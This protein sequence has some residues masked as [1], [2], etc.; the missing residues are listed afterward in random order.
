MNIRQI[1][2]SYSRFF[3]ANSTPASPRESLNPTDLHIKYFILIYFQR[4]FSFSERENKNYTNFY[5]TKREKNEQGKAIC[6][7]QNVEEKNARVLI[8][9][10]RK[11]IIHFL[12]DCVCLVLWLFVYPPS[13]Y[14]HKVTSLVI[15]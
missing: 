15:I 1:F 8:T 14:F 11:T 5:C 2:Y 12:I 7:P 6:R 9:I 10:N 3:N 4:L 13:I